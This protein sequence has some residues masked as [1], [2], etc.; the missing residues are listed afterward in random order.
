MAL[1]KLGGSETGATAKAKINLAFDEVDNNL[2]DMVAAFQQIDLNA[3]VEYS[4]ISADR[5]KCQC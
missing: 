1:D 3:S 5:L 2:A 4:S